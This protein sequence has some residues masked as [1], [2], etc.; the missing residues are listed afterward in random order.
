MCTVNWDNGSYDDNGNGLCG[1]VVYRMKVVHTKDFL[2]LKE[3]ALNNPERYTVKGI[4]IID[5][6]AK[7]IVV[8][9]DASDFH[10]ETDVNNFFMA[11]RFHFANGDYNKQTGIENVLS[12]PLESLSIN[13][14]LGTT[15]KC[16]A[17]QNYELIDSDNVLISHNSGEG[18]YENEYLTSVNDYTWNH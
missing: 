11:Y 1:T 13:L 5:N 18:D 17:Y 10:L 4:D 7:T 3:Q 9:C 2:A 16:D 14:P 8:N 15:V 6:E 12:T